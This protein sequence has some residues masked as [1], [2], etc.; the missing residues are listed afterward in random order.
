MNFFNNHVH[1]TMLANVTSNDFTLRTHFVKD[2]GLAPKFELSEDFSY[3]ISYEPR[4]GL[5]GLLCNIK[6]FQPKYTLCIKEATGVSDFNPIRWI[7]IYRW[8]ETIAYQLHLSIIRTKRIEHLKVIFNAEE[9][10]NTKL[11]CYNV[12][13]HAQIVNVRK[14]YL[15]LKRYN[16]GELQNILS[17]LVK[18]EIEKNIMGYGGTPSFPIVNLTYHSEKELPEAEYFIYTE[19]GYFINKLRIQYI[20]RI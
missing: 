10:G 1:S 9:G 16:N 19:A 5:R 11:Y 3:V 12:Y 6:Y 2:F 18:G 14:F 20:N 17:N 4:N 8:V 13:I 15:F 7:P